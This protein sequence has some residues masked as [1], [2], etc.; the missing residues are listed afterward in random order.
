MRRCRRLA[1][2]G[3]VG[4]V[5]LGAVACDDDGDTGAGPPRTATPAEPGGA[6][7]T[8]SSEAGSSVPAGTPDLE[9]V[10]IAL[11]PVAAIDTP[12]ALAVRTG[13]D[14]L[15]V[16][17]QAGRVLAVRDG[18]VD[19]EPVL[20]LS[21]QVTAG[22]E[23]GLL[24]LAFSTDGDR[25]YVHYSNV[26]GDTRVDEYEMGGRAAD[27]S[28]RRAL[29]AVDQPQAN[30]NGG[31]LSFGPDGLL[32][33]GLGDGG[34]GGDT[35]PGHAPGGNGQSL[36]TLLGKILRIDPR[37]AGGDAYTVPAD[38][39]FADGGGRPEIYAYGLRNPWRFSFDRETG[40]LWIGDVG[41]NAWEEIDHVPAGEG[42]GANFGWPRL[43]GSQPFDGEA[44]AG[45]IGP[46]FE[47]PNPDQGCSV[48]GGYVYRGSAIPELVG[49]Y[50]FA[51][52]C[53]AELRALVVADGELA[54]EASLG[55]TSATVASFGEDDDGELYVLSQE[56]GLLRIDPA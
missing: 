53:T 31:Q 43:E 47:Y 16:T 36:D 39:P 18:E 25:L 32:Y 35:G 37:P 54:T 34:G 52:Y 45:A 7:T 20:D 23:Q 55:V 28:S 5:A 29:L 27:A 2:V 40:D 21:D 42:A 1:A 46:V 48:T 41:Q 56:A 11:T 38:N 8:P 22:G 9:A 6:S 4:L 15:Y 10:A 33:L 44:P 24:G 49:A 50:V 3:L 19:P 12:T 30:H 17:E 51:D 13:D 26:D 14:A